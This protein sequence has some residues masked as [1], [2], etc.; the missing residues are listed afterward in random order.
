MNDPGEIRGRTSL[1]RRKVLLGLGMAAVSGVAYAR[2]PVPNRPPLEADAFEGLI[3][4]KIGEWRFMTESGLVLPPSD[5]LSDRLYDNLV[6]RAYANPAGQTLMMLIAYNNRQDGILQIHRPEICYP[7]G[8]YTLTETR[9]VD[10]ALGAG[11]VLPAHA[12]IAKS[13]QRDEAVLYWT[14]VGETFPQRWVEQR[15]SVASANL[16]G[17]IPDGLLV[18]ISTLGDD[19]ATQFPVMRG[20]IADLAE[21][22]SPRLAQLLFDGLNLA[23]NA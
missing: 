14:R 4:D 19:F 20:F 1:D 9:A 11:G 8:G 18:R 13:R 2:L 17:V 6:T 12:F 21:A 10:V 3:P 15:L 7:A 5:A 23:R 22:S 16:K